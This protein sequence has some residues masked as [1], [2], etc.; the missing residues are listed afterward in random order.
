[1]GVVLVVEVEWGLTG[2]LWA[3]EL[4]WGRW[5]LVC[6]WRRDAGKRTRVSVC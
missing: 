1:M 6:D 3:L 4:R 2:L 5:W